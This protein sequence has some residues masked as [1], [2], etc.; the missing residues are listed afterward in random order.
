M[1]LVGL[2]VTMMKACYWWRCLPGT[3]EDPG[4]HADVCVHGE[5]DDEGA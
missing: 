5:G 3:G 2:D 1:T 4:V